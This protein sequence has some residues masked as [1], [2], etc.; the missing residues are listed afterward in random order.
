MAFVTKGFGLIYKRLGPTGSNNADPHSWRGYLPQFWFTGSYI[1]GSSAV[2]GAFFNFPAD[3]GSNKYVTTRDTGSPTFKALP[4][5]SFACDLLWNVMVPSWS[6]ADSSSTQTPYYGG[7][8]KTVV[9]RTWTVRTTSTESFFRYNVPQPD[10]LG[11]TKYNV[12][13]SWRIIDPKLIVNGGLSA[14]YYYV[15]DVQGDTAYPTYV[16]AKFN[17]LMP[18]SSSVYAYDITYPTLNANSTS[19][20]DKQYFDLAGGA[21]ITRAEVSA[22]MATVRDNIGVTG[23]TAA[24]NITRALKSRRL[25]FPTSYS[26]SGTS[27]GTDYWFR[28]LTGYK[29]SD[30]F[31]ENGGIY[32]IQLTIKRSPTEYGYYPDTGSFLSVFLYNVALGSVVSQAG[33]RVPGSAGWYPPDNNIVKIGNGYGGTPELSFYD[34]QSGY[35]IEKFNFNIVQY[36][37]PAQLCI[38]PSGSLTDNAYFGVIVDDIKICKIGVTTDPAFIKPTTIAGRTLNAERAP[39]GEIP[40]G[41]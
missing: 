14:S 18:E 15:Q 39:I 16:G 28:A 33:L 1:T 22:S 31:T 27:G 17:A 24:L 23:G 21:G 4:W 2:S 34:V 9:D 6:Y 20:W 3:S 38:E 37:Y 41:E 35:L 12:T 5:G 36:G 11:V 26:G 30:V 7:G 25:F 32:N 19:S 40:S 8:D 10:S 13:S 29:I